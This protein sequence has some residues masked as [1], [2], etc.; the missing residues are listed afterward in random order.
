MTDNASTPAHHSCSLKTVIIGI[1]SWLK[2]SQKIKVQVEIKASLLK[3]GYLSVPLI[4]IG[5]LI[6]FLLMLGQ[7][8]FYA[9][10]HAFFR[11]A[12][13]E[14][15]AKLSEVSLMLS[16]L[17]FLGYNLYLIKTK[18]QNFL[19]AMCA[20]GNAELMRRKG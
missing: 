9:D 12:S 2:D 7:C 20:R 8:L 13:T 18:V 6:L 10:S 16:S 19:H 15:L 5:L 3:S 17:L 1:S 11:G 4:R 14:T